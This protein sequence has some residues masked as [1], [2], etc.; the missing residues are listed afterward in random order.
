MKLVKNEN[1]QRVKLGLKP[2]KLLLLR[3][4]RDPSAKCRAKQFSY[5]DGVID[6]KVEM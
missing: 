2:G 4:W 3:V 5:E 6:L 1:D